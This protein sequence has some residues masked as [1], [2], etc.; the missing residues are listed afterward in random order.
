[1]KYRYFII[2]LLFYS[3]LTQGIGQYVTVSPEINIRSDIAFF[4][5][6][7]IDNNILLFRDLGSEKKLHIYDQ[8]LVLN[9]E[10]QVNLIEK[11]SL[12]YDLVN[13]DTAFA[14]FYGF[15]DEKEMVVQLDIFSPT[16]ELIDSIEISRN[17]RSFRALQ[18]KATVSEDESKVALFNILSDEKI[19]ISVFDLNTKKPLIN[20]D[21]IISNTNLNEELLQIE[22]SNKGDLFM[23]TE[24]NNYKSDKKAHEVNI[25]RFIAT[26]E[27]TE[28]IR[29][30]LYDVITASTLFKIDNLNSRIG[31]SALY[32]EKS[33]NESTGYIWTNG[34]IDNWGNED[35]YLI[36][37]EDVVYYELYGDKKK[38]KLQDFKLKD[39]L[40]KADGTPILI[41]EV[42]NNVSRQSGSAASNTL[43]PRAFRSGTS[44]F[45]GWSDHYREDI[46]I[47]SLDE[48]IHEEWHQVFYKKQFSQNDQ[49]IYSSFFT[50][51]TPSRIRLLFND[52]IKT[53][54]TV[55]EYIF[56]GAGN[57]KR[58]SVLN[59]EYQNLRLRFADALQISNSSLLVPSQKSYDLNIV[60]IDYSR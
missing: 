33:K 1:M 21:Y 23:L 44:N 59:T 58:S 52:E 24:K 40:F 53:S 11:R 50:F 6:G 27:I 60:K 18:Y 20:N 22:V 36:P 3:S 29:I 41:M 54:S 35:I 14:V 25:L 51:N 31:L 56:D 55:S 2:L 45:T 38:K 9:S 12:V 16:A 26:S 17:E 30:P 8:D 43:N 34:P 42:E 46:L 37:F 10:R 32:D 49:G 15:R 4:L 13:L 7:E 57:Y 19:R 47:I 48:T 5:L 28:E 39:I